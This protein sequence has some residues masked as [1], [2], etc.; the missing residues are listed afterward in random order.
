MDWLALLAHWMPQLLVAALGTLKLTISAFLVG[1]VMGLFLAIARTSRSSLLRRCAM[2]YIDVV[3]GIPAVVVLFLIYFGLAPYG[4]VLD[5]FSAAVIGLGLSAAA[6]LAEIFRA[7][8]QAIHV[9]QREAAEMIGMRRGQVMRYVLFPQ[10]LRVVLPPTVNYAIA[11]LKDSSV[12][13]LISAP[14][15]MLRTRDLTSEFFMPLQLYL[16][17]SAIYLSLSYP[18]SLAATYLE[19]RLAGAASTNS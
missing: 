2:V 6:Y 1:A 4:V 14:E 13:S 7:G 19:R 18:L 8:L 10:A 11:L 3:R 12:A 17:V 15:L 9:G 5:A 16:V